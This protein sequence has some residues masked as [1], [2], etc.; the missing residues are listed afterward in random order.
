MSAAKTRITFHGSAKTSVMPTKSVYM[1][2]LSLV[3]VHTH[4][5]QLRCQYEEFVALLLPVKATFLTDLHTLSYVRR[6]RLLAKV[7]ATATVAE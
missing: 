6:M 2:S 5:L 4:S 1:L 7:K 3:V